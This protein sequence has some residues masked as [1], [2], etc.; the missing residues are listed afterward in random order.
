MNNFNHKGKIMSLYPYW[1]TG[2]LLFHMIC[3]CNC[4]IIDGK[5][6]CS[7]ECFDR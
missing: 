5:E 4:M 1:D 6:A 2:G 3:I 7:L